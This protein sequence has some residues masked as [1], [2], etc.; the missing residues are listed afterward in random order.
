SADSQYFVYERKNRKQNKDNPTEFM[1]VELGTWKQHLLDVGWNMTGCAITREGIFYYLKRTSR[2]EVDLM[3]ADLSKGQPQV[4]FRLRHPAVAGS[5]GTVSP[6]SRYYA[7]GQRLDQ[8]YKRFGV[9]LVDLE[10]GTETVID[11][12]PY[13]Y[14]THPQFD[15]SRNDRLMIQHN[16]GSKFSPE[17]VRERAIGPEGAILYL[18]SVPDAKRAELQVGHPYTTFITGHEAWIATSGEILFS[19]VARDDYVPEKGN[20]LRVRPGEPARVAARGFQ[21]NHVNVSRCGRFFCCDDWRGTCRIVIGSLQT[22][23]TAAVCESKASMQRD[24]NTHPH[25]YLTP[26]LKWIVFNSD[27]SGFPHIHAASVP[28]GLMESLSRPA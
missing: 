7:R 14:N 24:A 8:E 6:D 22:G 23:R 17:G 2:R 9:L 13:N 26:D 21:A 25:A 27:R 16:R 19:V 28:P 1:V 20:L 12:D 18:L 15:P 10:K 11:E 4:I 3:R 5:L